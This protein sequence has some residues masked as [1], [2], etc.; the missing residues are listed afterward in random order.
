MSNYV[1]ELAED[2]TL[3]PRIYLGN[4]LLIRDRGEHYRHYLVD[5]GKDSFELYNVNPNNTNT[6]YTVRCPK[7]SSRLVRATLNKYQCVICKGKK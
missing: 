5:K 3:K 2:G 7:C 1:L 6:N 4:V